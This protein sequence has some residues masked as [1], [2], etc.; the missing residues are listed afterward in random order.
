MES[1]RTVAS[2]KAAG[3]TRLPRGARGSKRRKRENRG[4][5][6]T[7]GVRGCPPPNRLWGLGE[8]RELPQRGPG[9]S[10][11]RQCIFGIFEAH[12]TDHKSSIFHKMSTQSI[13]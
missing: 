4:A 11:G 13:D 1:C 7:E 10:P 12:R 8:R 2:S 3:G 9:R 6:G 5:E